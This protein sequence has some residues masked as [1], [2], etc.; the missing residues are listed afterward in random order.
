MHTFTQLA[1]L[2][3]LATTIT[4]AHP[5][6]RDD[7]DV[8]CGENIPNEYIVAIKDIYTRDLGHRSHLE[9]FNDIPGVMEPHRKIHIGSW[10]GLSG[11]FD[12]EALAWV[13]QQPFVESISNNT[14]MCTTEVV[15]QEHAPWGLTAI[16]HDDRLSDDYIYDNLGGFGSGFGTAVFHLDTGLRDTH[17]DFAKDETSTKALEQR[18][19][20]DSGPT[21][22]EGEGDD[23]DHNGHGTHAAGTIIGNK[24]GVAKAADFVSIKVGDR[25]GT[26]P[27]DRVLQGF[28]Y[29]VQTIEMNSLYSEAVISIGLS[30]SRNIVWDR[31]IQEAHDMGILTIVAAGNDG[32]DAA[33]HSPA[34]SP[35]ALTVGAVSKPN[36]TDSGALIF[37]MSSFSNTGSVVDI[38]A[39]GNDI[40]SASHYGNDESVLKS[41]TSMAA[42]HV[43][44]LVLYLKSLYPDETKTPEDTKGKLL[45]M[46]MSD[47]IRDPDQ[48]LNGANNKVAFNGCKDE[49]P[50]AKL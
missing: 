17:N 30:G 32:G 36:I 50:G 47:A 49:K 48:R 42:N 14:L 22:V 2:A 8:R 7:G 31:V 9:S 34:S 15:R 16:S 25:Y 21:F 29:A 38:F 35:H 5:V 41:G 43:T 13:S 37:E 26:A 18:S 10:H 12:D 1:A 6:K 46:A 45:D 23:M 24:F 19:G 39:P 4:S 28:E 27:L 44:G 40:E 33:A 11:W 20:V 3:A